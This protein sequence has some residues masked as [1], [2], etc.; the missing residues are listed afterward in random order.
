MH[1]LLHST[2]PPSSP[3]TTNTSIPDWFCLNVKQSPQ[4]TLRDDPF[5]KSNLRNNNDESEKK[6]FV[7]ALYLPN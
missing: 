3:T 7:A 2:N 1:P 4:K 5:L 6:Y